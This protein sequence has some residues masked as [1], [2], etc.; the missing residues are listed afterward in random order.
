MSKDLAADYFSRHLSSNECYITSDGRVFH[1]KGTADGFANGLEDHKVLSYTRSEVEDPKE[2]APSADDAT[3]KIQ[4]LSLLKSFD[5]TSAA[6]PEI[7]ALVKDLGLQAL[8]QS[9]ED[10]LAAI[11]AFK[12]ACNTEVQA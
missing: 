8:T 11:E 9:K 5:P 6:Y 10:L 7:K 2:E 12:V 1:S 3:T 4:A